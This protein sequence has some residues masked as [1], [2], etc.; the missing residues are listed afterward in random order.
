MSR[1]RLIGANH[2]IVNSGRHDPAFYRELWTTISRRPGLAWR[3]LQP[4]RRRA[5]STGST[6]RVVPLKDRE[7]EVVQFIAICTDITARKRLEQELEDSRAFLQSVTNSMGEGV[8]TIDARGRCTF[9]NAEA[10]RLIGWS[11]EEVRG[12]SLHDLVHF[13]D[14]S[15]APHPRAAIARSCSRCTTPQKHHSE[16]QYF[17][18]RDGRVFPV[19]VVAQRL[20]QDGKYVGAVVVFQDITERRRVHDELK[21]SEQRLSVA[22]SAS[23]TGLW[24][25]NPITDHGRL[26]RDLVPHARLRAAP[27]TPCN[28]RAVPLAAASRR[29]GGLPRARWSSTCAARPTAVEVEFRMRRA[30][31]DWAWIRSIG[32]I[33][34]LDPDGRPQR[35][36]GVHIDTSA[37]HQ[38]QSELASAKDVAVRANQAKS[39]FLATMS[40]EIRTP[41]NAI[42]G[43]SHLMG[44]T[45]L[46]PRQRDYLDQ[47]PERLARA[48]RRSSTTS[49]ISRRSRPASSISK[50]SSSISTRC[51]RTSPRSSLRSVAE[52]GLKLRP[53]GA[54]ELPAHFV[55]DPLRLSQVLMNLLSNAAKFTV[56]GRNRAGRRRA[57]RSTTA[58]S[59]WKSRCRI[60]ASA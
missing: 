12:K 25:Y 43:L 53:R 31:G 6:R 57:V 47:D 54:P 52:K 55:G 36:I 40:H 48:A 13:Q 30:D 58:A 9:L 44:R 18:H 4:Q 26:Q 42:I 46:A 50:P 38:I 29:L 34:E 45:E 35:L 32:K 20:E 28:G 19:S 41:M 56:D 10:E 59:G 7:G 1:E 17:T 5:S 33:I 11:F 51:S 27:A 60:P 49:S 23:S 37:A 8:Y 16:D 22:L 39:D 2:N 15:G 21:T 3:D 24:D 14:E